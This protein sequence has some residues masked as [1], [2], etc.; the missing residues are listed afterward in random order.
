M[1]D[2]LPDYFF[3]IRENGAAVYRLGTGPRDRR[4][5]MDQIAVVNTRNGEVKPHG[6][7][8]LTAAD[9]AAIADWLAARRETLARRET[10]EIARTIETLNLAAHW[11]QTRA[12]EEELEALTGPLLLAMH[13]LRTVLVRKKADRL[14]RDP[15]PQDSSG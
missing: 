14:S 13:D 2:R 11:A 10:D 8:A 12:T 7:R 3:R 1:M 4:I 6:T 9:E 15:A 5:E